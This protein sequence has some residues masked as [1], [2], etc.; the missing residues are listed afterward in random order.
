MGKD[1]QAVTEMKK[2]IEVAQKAV[3]D[4]PENAGSILALADLNEILARWRPDEAS[5]KEAVDGYA[6]V[7][8]KQPL[9]FQVYVKAAAAL[10]QAKKY[11]EAANWYEKLLAAAM[12]DADP[13][14]LAPERSVFVLKAAAELAW[15]HAEYLNDLDKAQKYAKIASAIKPDEPSLIDTTGWIQYKSGKVQD[16]LTLLRQAHQ[17]L[18]TNA[19]VAYHL[20]LAL[21][22]NKKTA[23][24]REMLQEALK[25]VKSDEALKAQIQDALKKLGGT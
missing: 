22:K 24:G 9:A 8:N 14:S 12:G 25:N 18:P 19:T 21:V 23:E 20:G 7:V 13:R 15:I 3:K 2:L 17:G 10:E 6:L 11:Q 4:E 5:L 1:E 16:A